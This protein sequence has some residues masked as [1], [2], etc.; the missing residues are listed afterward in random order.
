M[1]ALVGA[2]LCAGLIGVDAA[3]DR[4]PARRVEVMINGFSLAEFEGLTKTVQEEFSSALSQDVMLALALPEAAIPPENILWRAG[5][6]SS[7]RAYIL[8][9]LSEQEKTVVHTT[10]A[11]EAAP[12]GRWLLTY[13]DAK[14]KEQGL[15]GAESG[16]LVDPSTKSSGPPPPPD[17]PTVTRCEEELRADTRCTVG[18]EATGA[19]QV[20]ICQQEGY[21]CDKRR[22]ECRKLK[23]AGGGGTN[24]FEVVLFVLVIGFALFCGANCFFFMRYNRLPY[25][26]QNMCCTCPPIVSC[27]KQDDKGPSIDELKS[28]TGF[29]K[30]RT[31]KNMLP[32]VRK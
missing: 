4:T 32:E 24:F 15:N 3:E 13:L 28:Q 9:V 10:F 1:R 5:G 26:T 22:G 19:L 25:V 21:A 2:V 16:P 14:A 27:E 29:K 12:Q 18:A 6:D 8:L 31:I 23:S 11:S 17:S 30:E 20:C 7:V